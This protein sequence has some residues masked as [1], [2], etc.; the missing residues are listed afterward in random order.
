MAFQDNV[1]GEVINIGPDEEFVTII[2]LAETIAD[3][4]DFGLKPI[5]AEDRPQEVK[6]AN[7]S[8]EKARKLLDYETKYSLRE[9]LQIMIDWINETGIKPFK[10]HLPL[11]IKNEK[12]PLTWLKKLF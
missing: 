10:Y 5:Y 1:I 8:A 4:I 3:L 12:V 9:G 2:Q 7:C 6:L 11:E